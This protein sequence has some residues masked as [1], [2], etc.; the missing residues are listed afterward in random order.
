MG[1]KGL[2]WASRAVL[3]LPWLLEQLT[4][5]VGK[6][7]KEFSN[8]K[9]DSKTCLTLPVF[10]GLSCPSTILGMCVTACTCQN[11]CPFARGEIT[12]V[13]TG[14]LLSADLGIFQPLLQS[15]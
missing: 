4:P 11:H 5:H 10:V 7:R 1:L 9:A 15:Q 13:S 2:H 8:G 6:D 3:L 14:T 12:P